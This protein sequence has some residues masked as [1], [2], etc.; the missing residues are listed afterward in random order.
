MDEEVAMDAATTA[1]AEQE[2]DPIQPPKHIIRFA[3]EASKCSPCRSKRGVA[4]FRGDALMNTGHNYK[5]R[6]FVC[7][8]SAACKAT[9]RGEAIH[10]EQHALLISGSYFAQDSEM[11]H[12]KTVDGELVPSG[13][14]SCV[15]CSKLMTAAG[16]SAMWLYH[17]HGWQRYDI[18]TFHRESLKARAASADAA[19]EQ[20]QQESQ[21]L[22]DAARARDPHD[23]QTA[24]EETT[25]QLQ[26]AQQEITRLTAEREALQREN[27][28][29]KAQA[30]PKCAD[31]VECVATNDNLDAAEAELTAL[32][33]SLSMA[34]QEIARLKAAAS[35]KHEVSFGKPEV[36]LDPYRFIRE[37]FKER[38]RCQWHDTEHVE[39]VPER[40]GEFYCALCANEA[41]MLETL[42]PRPGTRIAGSGEPT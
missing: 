25:Q 7:D 40:R 42:K 8:G 19:L 28:R 36:S 12:V 27:A 3:V 30:M 1:A 29:L 6:P 21:R 13:G 4:I 15:E 5:P 38:G 24:W 20:A 34:E 10:A 35:G 22:R 16:I 32:R 41:R 26:E 33:S 23:Y 39:M 2:A 17:E 14:P 37:V 11:L 18:E 9:C 31:L